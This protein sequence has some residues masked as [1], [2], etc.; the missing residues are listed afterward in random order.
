M[1]LSQLPALWY[2]QAIGNAKT[3]RNDNS[4]RFGKYLEI[5]F[6]K[7]HHITGAHMRTYLLEKS[8]VVFQAPEERNYH[9][10]YQLCASCDLPEL[11]DLRLGKTLYRFVHKEHIFGAYSGIG[12][13]GISQL[14]VLGLL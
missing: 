12:I 4:S 5:S 2:F 8:R 3:I 13:V 11:K 6:D 14:F 1:T 9:I 7:N 10:F